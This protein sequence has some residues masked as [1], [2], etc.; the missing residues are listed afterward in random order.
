MLVGFVL[1]GIGAVAASAH[2]NLVGLSILGFLTFAGGL[3]YQLYG[4]RCPRCHGRIGFALNGFGNLFAVPSHFRF[5]PF[6][7]VSLDAE[8]DAP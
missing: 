1:F 3:V 5:C 2:P 7:G 4:I 8:T 6:C